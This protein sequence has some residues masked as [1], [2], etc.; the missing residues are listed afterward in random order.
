MPTWEDAFQD[1]SESASISNIVSRTSNYMVRKISSL[2]FKISEERLK[3]VDT[4][5]ILA[6]QASAIIR[7]L[8]ALS[9]YS[10][11]VDDKYQ[12]IEN[13]ESLSANHEAF[14]DVVG[15]LT[16]TVSDILNSLDDKRQYSV[17]IVCKDKEKA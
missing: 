3:G 17:N 5:V 4:K 14:M 8:L 15:H 6:T 13:E 2:L 9:L 11:K 1:L 10:L 7:M 12:N 16:S